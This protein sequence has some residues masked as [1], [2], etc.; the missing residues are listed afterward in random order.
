MKFTKHLNAI[1][2]GA[3][4]LSLGISIVV[5]VILG[6]VCGLYLKRLSGSWLLF[7]LF[8]AFGVAAAFLNVY[9]AYK[10]LMRD[11]KELEFMAKNGHKNLDENSTKY[12]EDNS[13]TA[14]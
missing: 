7:W 9:K 4:T 1:V 14:K 3:N 6:V 8:V 10:A 2:R 5:A 12:D 11:A 13:K